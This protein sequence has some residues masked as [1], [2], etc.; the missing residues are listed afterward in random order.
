MCWIA[1]VVANQIITQ[2]SLRKNEDDALDILSIKK[3][4]VAHPSNMERD[5][6]SA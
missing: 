4:F 6:A 5:L 3:L 1:T 2:Y